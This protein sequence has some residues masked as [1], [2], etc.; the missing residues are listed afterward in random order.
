MQI[1]PAVDPTGTTRSR[2]KRCGTELYNGTGTYSIPTMPDLVKAYP[3]LL[4]L[5]VADRRACVRR[6][7]DG[8]EMVSRH[9]G[10][11]PGRALRPCHGSS[12]DAEGRA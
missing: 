7:A 3:E 8:Q 2:Y 6:S 1:S 11:L 10:V 5:G 4:Q 9:K 12:I